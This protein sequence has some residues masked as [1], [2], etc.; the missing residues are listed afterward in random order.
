MSLIYYGNVPP[1][2][3][4]ELRTRPKLKWQRM[5][6]RMRE[7]PRALV[8][9]P[10]TPDAVPATPVQCDSTLDTAPTDGGDS[11]TLTSSIPKFRGM[12]AG[13]QLLFCNERLV[14]WTDGSC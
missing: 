13:R 11:G 10:F 3:L 5:S 12:V 14:V 8:S 6:C 1:G 4:F 9:T 2:S 7:L